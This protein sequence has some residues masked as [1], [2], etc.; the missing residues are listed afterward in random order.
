MTL[1]EKLVEGHPGQQL[2]VGSQNVPLDAL[3]VVVLF[4][5]PVGEGKD[6]GSIRVDLGFVPAGAVDGS[7]ADGLVPNLAVT[8]SGRA[9]AQR[10]DGERVGATDRGNGDA[11]F[12]E[13]SGPPGERVDWCLDLAGDLRSLRVG[14]GG[15]I[16]AS[17]LGKRVGQR[18]ERRPFI[19]DDWEAQACRRPDRWA[20]WCRCAD[21][22]DLW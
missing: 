16:G 6:H 18:F 5:R 9:F 8:A 10:C 1:V 17:R 15:E 14:D 11:G 13:V 21:R 7:I 12:S 19:G 20:R 4:D 22:F 3:V 2:N